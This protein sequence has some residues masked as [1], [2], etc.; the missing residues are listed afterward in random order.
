MSE[1]RSNQSYYNFASNFSG[2]EGRKR[3]LSQMEDTQEQQIK[4]FRIRRRR[5]DV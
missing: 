4:R 1:G 5:I 3:I 2:H